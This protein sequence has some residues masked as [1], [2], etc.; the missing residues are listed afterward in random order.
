ME[1]GLQDSEATP[2]DSDSK[3]VR[4][5]KPSGTRLELRPLGLPARLQ[6]TVPS[7]ITVFLECA[8]P[9]EDSPPEVLPRAHI[10]S[11]A[12][13]DASTCL[14]GDSGPRGTNA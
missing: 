12:L 4:T 1:K 3:L 5:R 8:G 6:S 7:P 11:S 14:L 10:P 13:P 2:V 9:S